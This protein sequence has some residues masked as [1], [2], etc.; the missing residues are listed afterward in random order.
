MDPMTSHPAAYDL[1]LALVIGA[2]LAWACWHIA[3]A[4]SSLIP[5]KH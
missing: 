1:L 4:I 5:P 3:A 2:A